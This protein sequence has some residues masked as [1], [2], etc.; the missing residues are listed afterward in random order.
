MKKSV[1]FTSLAAFCLA[2]LMLPQTVHA[3]G[4]VQDAAGVKYQNDDGSFLVDSW[5]QIGQNIYHLDANGIVQTGWI[6]VGDLWYFLDANGVCTNPA[7]TTTPPAELAAAAAP[8]P[9]ATTAAAPAAVPTSS[10]IAKMFAA[11]GWVPFQ[12]TDAA[13]LSNGIAARLV[14]TDGA[15]YWAEPT[16][17]AA[18]Q[19]LAAQTTSSPVTSISPAPSITDQPVLPGE[20]TVYITNTG[21]KYHRAGCRY[22]RESQYSISLSNAISQNYTP[23]KV[24]VPPVK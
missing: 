24:C 3:A 6:Q 16:F 4:F 1:L 17:A 19:A 18:V 12:T 11:A 21:S 20:T 15:Q 9:A 23:C 22:L 13:L 7:G 2:F 14:G 5:V 8:V 10:D